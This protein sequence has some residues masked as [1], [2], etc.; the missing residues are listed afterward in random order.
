MNIVKDII[1]LKI[2]RNIMEMEILFIDHH[3]NQKFFFWCDNN[4]NVIE[5]SAESI[6]IPYLFEVDRKIHRYYPDVIAKIKTNNGIKK[7]IIE[8][9]PYKQTNLS[10]RMSDNSK[11]ISI[12]NLSKFS[13]A[14]KLC[15][16]EGWEF[17][18]LTEKN[19]NF[20]K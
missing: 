14:K 13:A 6:A 12:V 5:W 19:V 10:K 4:E 8:I 15:Q 17:L 3:M 2:N 9:K 7:F 11:A 1:Y 16:H 20:I 18:V